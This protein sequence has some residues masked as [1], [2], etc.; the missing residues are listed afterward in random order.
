MTNNT[1]TTAT[2]TEVQTDT[3]ATTAEVQTVTVQ[4]EATVLDLS[5]MNNLNKRMNNTM[6]EITGLA[7]VFGLSNN[8]ALNKFRNAKVNSLSDATYE[9]IGKETGHIMMQI[10][11][12]SEMTE[13]TYAELVALNDSFFIALEEKLLAPKKL[14]EEAAAK[15]LEEKK[16][17]KEA[18]D[19]AKKEKEAKE[20]DE[21]V[22]KEDAKVEAAPIDIATPTTVAPAGLPDGLGI[23]VNLSE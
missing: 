4:K 13:E 17:A 8:T 18:K 1:N 12:P 5:G 19:L 11:V 2:T 16:L 20:N 14:K 21:Y 15:K 7:K 9:T 6:N 22:E 23:N 10:M 3:V